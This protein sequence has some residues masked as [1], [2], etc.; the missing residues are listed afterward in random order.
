[1]GDL[2]FLENHKDRK[3]QYLTE[4]HQTAEQPSGLKNII[5]YPHQ[6]TALR[7]MLDL[8]EARMLKIMRDHC[9]DSKK[10]YIIAETSALL[11]SEEFGAGKTIEVLALIASRQIPRAIPTH[12]SWIT[13]HLDCTLGCVD[14]VVKYEG[15]DV[16]IRPN[17][18]F[19]HS[20]ILVQW[21]NAISEFT[22]LKYLKVGNYHELLKFQELYNSSNLSQYNIVLVKYG[23]VSGDLTKFGLDSNKQ[24]YSIVNLIRH[25]TRDKCWSRVIYDDFDTCPTPKS[26]LVPALFT[27]YVSASATFKPTRETP[28]NVSGG[29]LSAYPAINNA[30]WDEYLISNFNIRCAKEYV[31]GSVNTT[32]VEC[33]RYRSDNPHEIF[34]GFVKLLGDKNVAQMLNGDAIHTAAASIGIATNNAVGIFSHLLSAR[35]NSY[36]HACEMIKT[37]ESYMKDMETLPFAR[38]EQ[39][40]LDLIRSKIEKREEVKIDYN[41]PELRKTLTDISNN[42]KRVKERIGKDISRVLDNVREGMCQVCTLPLEDTNVFINK[43]CGLITCD[44]CGVTCN[45]FKPSGLPS[46]PRSGPANL[47][48]SCANCKRAINMRDDM[49]FIDKSYKIEDLLRTDIVEES[50]KISAKAPR[51]NPAG[52]A[53]KLPKKDNSKVRIL[54]DILRGIVP[55]GREKIVPRIPSLLQGNKNIPRG[56][57]TPT[58]FLVFANFEESL[59]LVERTLKDIGEPYLMLRGTY[60]E[61]ARILD[62]FRNGSERVLLINSQKNCAGLNLQFAT[63]LIFMHKIIDPAIEAQVAGRAQRIGRTC[64]LNIHYILYDNEMGGPAND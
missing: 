51:V 35:Y 39:D 10:P 53:E 41:C 9:F 24:H 40:E 59:R 48:G 20:S 19:V 11:L 25:I 13:S 64:N 30:I 14:V 16:L 45:R 33:Y 23:N 26:L 60:A 36:I 55:E 1:M 15:P 17:L 43:C 8:E 31:D 34:I 47:S 29:L 32:V 57:E 6:K 44:I 3:I 4:N 22:D 37:A 58:K 63:D 54:T 5:L 56:P 2:S 7:A 50:K 61:R 49:I 27:I 52:S 18:I 62:K 28:L 38:Y 12:M 42:Y 46:D 21:C